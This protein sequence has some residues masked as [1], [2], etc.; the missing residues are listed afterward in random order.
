VLSNFLAGSGHRAELAATALAYI[1][2]DA[3]VDALLQHYKATTDPSMKALIAT[4]M[5]STRLTAANRAFLEDCL[6]GEHFGTEWMPI[7][8]A[9]FSLGVLRSSESQ[10]ALEATV[11]KA[12]GSISSGA[13]EEALR[14]ISQGHWN[15]DIPSTAK[16]ESPITAVLRNGIPRTEDGGR[17]FD[18]ARH[19]YWVLK[20]NTWTVEEKSE[21]RDAPSMSFRLHV[22]PDEAR[23]LVSVGITFGPLNGAGYDYVLRK[24][25]KDW[26]VQSVFFTWIS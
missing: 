17:Y 13:A 16:V 15:V 11:K 19:F 3:A 10:G 24:V 2:G 25:D 9:S 22:S 20:G 5:G 7:V 14:W 6:Q 21:K 4:A 18:S 8:S 23:A 26:I 1:G 12:S